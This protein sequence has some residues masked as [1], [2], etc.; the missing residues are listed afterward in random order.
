MNPAHSFRHKKSLGQHFLRDPDI[1]ERILDA[2]PAEAADA[3]VLEIGAGAGVLTRPLF[4]AFGRKLYVSEIDHRS[5]RLIATDPGVS[6]DRI[7]EG[8]FL[9]C[10]LQELPTPLYIAGNFPYNISSQIV[11]RMLKHR[12]KIPAL[13]GMFQREMAVRICASPGNRDYGVISVWTNLFYS[14]EILF[15]LPPEAFDP[16]PKVHSAVIRL[17]KRAEVV[18]GADDAGVLKLVKM[19]FQQR[20]KKLSNALGAVDGAR[21][22]LEGFGWQDL[23]PEALEPVQYVQLYQAIVRS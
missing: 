1:A 3:A 12:E 20:R 16:P 8:D 19:A 15:E 23:R 21:Q 22:A 2:I 5:V 17:I 6:A 11:F 7:L 9:K 18:P 4:R 14:G 10:N 13:V